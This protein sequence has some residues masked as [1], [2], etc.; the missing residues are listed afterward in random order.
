MLTFSLTARSPPNQIR[1][2]ASSDMPIS[3]AAPLGSVRAGND[4]FDSATPVNGAVLIEDLKIVPGDDDYFAWT[5]SLNGKARFAIKFTYDIGQLDIEIY[6]PTR[7]LIS[8][9]SIAPDEE[10]E[11]GSDTAQTFVFGITAGTTYFVRVFGFPRVD[12]PY[13]LEI[14]ETAVS[15]PPKSDDFFS[16]GFESRK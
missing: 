12:N 5:A 3:G 6:N 15:N 2:S 7:E 16:D 10:G 14:V 4:D 1:P 8:G 11:L 13:T 9:V